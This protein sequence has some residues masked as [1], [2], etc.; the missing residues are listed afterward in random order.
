[1]IKNYKFLVFIGIILFAT[2]IKAQEKKKKKADKFPYVYATYSLQIPGDDLVTRFGTS[3]DIGGGVGYK[4]ETNWTIGV[5]ASYIFGNDVKE[6]PL[7]NLLN[8]H[9]QITNMYGEPSQIKMRQ[10]GLRISGNVGKIFAV[11]HTNKNSG[12]YLRGGIGFLQHKIYIENDGNNTPQ[13]LNDYRKGY[14]KL[15]NGM[16]FSEFIG[17]QN[18]SNN[19]GFHF[20]VGFEFVQAITENR[21]TWDYATN[22]KIE[23]QRLDLLYTF[24]IA[25]YIPF[26]R[27]QSNQYFYY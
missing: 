11:S 17:W 25:W 1:V 27:Q 5:E 15:C 7:E 19:G 21:R 2:A 9:N 13:V 20:I 14:D 16:S 8:S 22:T 26:R 4:T 3:S 12:I 24:K 10:S 23:G 6:N 18:F